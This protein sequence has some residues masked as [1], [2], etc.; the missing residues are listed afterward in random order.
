[1]DLQR[2]KEVTFLPGHPLCHCLSSHSKIAAR[3][4]AITSSFQAVGW[5]RTGGM[6]CSL[7]ILFL[8]LPQDTSIYMSLARQLHLTAREDGNG[9]MK[10]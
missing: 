2:H 5:M 1:M 10:N 8:K 9:P 6:M 4:P 3:A 7:N